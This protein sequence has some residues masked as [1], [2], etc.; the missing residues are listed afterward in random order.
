MQKGEK[1]NILFCSF[2]VKKI[3]NKK[4]HKIN[5]VSTMGSGLSLSKRARLAPAWLF[6]FFSGTATSG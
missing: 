4:Q 2:F 5:H 6:F 3:Q 1:G